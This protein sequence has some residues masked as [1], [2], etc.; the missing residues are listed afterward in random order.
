LRLAVKIQSRSCGEP[1]STGAVRLASRIWAMAE[2]QRAD[3]LASRLVGGIDFGGPYCP[4]GGAAAG[5]EA[6]CFLGAPVRSAGKVLSSTTLVFCTVKFP[7]S[8]TK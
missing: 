6:F 2:K 8:G 1:V 4:G 3:W 5:L 7:P